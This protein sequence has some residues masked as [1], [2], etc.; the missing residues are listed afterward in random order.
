MKRDSNWF[1]LDCSKDT[2]N[3]Y[4]GVHNHLWRQ[5][6]DR[7]QRHGMLC[8]SCLER[9]LGRHL[10]P[11]DFKLLPVDTEVAQ[12]LSRRPR[13]EFSNDGVGRASQSPQEFDDS[14]MDWDDYGLI[15]ELSVEAIN[16]IDAALMSLVT[17]EPRAIS[18]VISYTMEHS[19]AHVPGLPDYYYLDRVQILVENGKLGLVGNHD[20]LIKCKVFL[21][22][23]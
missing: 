19:P 11:E 9:R 7:S 13:T 3:E 21:P 20:E 2:F 14:P 10:Q 15:D 12:F 1:C 22:V 6:V 23:V 16:Q 8:L 17:T 18:Y 4:Y 5:A